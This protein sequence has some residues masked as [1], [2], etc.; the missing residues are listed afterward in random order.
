[1]RYLSDS[2]I[3]IAPSKT[4]SNVEVGSTVSETAI[5]VD[6]FELTSSETRSL[7]LEDGGANE[8]VF[9]YKK[10]PSSIDEVGLLN[11]ARTFSM[12]NLFLSNLF[13]N[14]IGNETPKTIDW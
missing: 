6:G 13:V 4:V 10:D 1:M 12:Y 3:E 5:T 8:I 9:E 14:I 2:G 7:T 11:D